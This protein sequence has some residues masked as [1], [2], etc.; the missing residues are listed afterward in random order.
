[1]GRLL[2][3]RIRIAVRNQAPDKLLRP[4]L[5]GPHLRLLL[6]VYHVCF[7][8]VRTDWLTNTFPFPPIATPEAPPKPPSKNDTDTSETGTNGAGE[9]TT[10]L[11]SNG[12][13]GSGSNGADSD[14][15][16]AET[17]ETP[18]A[19]EVESTTE[20]ENKAGNNKNK[21][22]K[23]SNKPKNP[24]ENGIATA[25]RNTPSPINTAFGQKDLFDMMDGWNS[26][27][28]KG[29]QNGG[30]S[31]TPT[32]GKKGGWLNSAVGGRK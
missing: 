17:A 13:P 12:V 24:A 26:T 15:E 20:G 31:S 4:L 27:P 6:M 1:M 7:R 18:D 10:S 16:T 30:R 21:N 25:D 11:Q 14:A 23:K 2:Q 9:S 19:A 22:K 29:D 32:R 3:L 5:R 28:T 8:I